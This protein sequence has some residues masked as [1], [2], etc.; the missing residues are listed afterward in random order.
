MW[1][2]KTI[3]LTAILLFLS[4]A[5]YVLLGYC[6][7]QDNFYVN[8][9]LYTVVF[10]AFIGLYSLRASLSTTTLWR[11]TLFM[12]GIL[13]CSIPA[14]SPDVYRF[15]WDGELIVK[16]IHPYAFTPNELMNSGTLE[17]TPYM[18]QLYASITDLSRANYS[19]YPTLNQLYFVIPAGLTESVFSGVVVMRLLMLLTLLVG[20]HFIQKT[21]EVLLIPK[22]RV[23]LFALNPLLIIEATG[24]L[25]FEGVMFSLFAIALYFMVR[26][27]W[28]VSALFVALAINVKLT[29][30]L[31]LPF[32]L[33]YLGWRKSMVFYLISLS[34]S[35]TLL[36]VF[37]WPSTTA[38]FLQS[39]ELYFNNFE[40]NSSLYRFSTYLFR[41]I[42][43]YDTALI[44][45]PLL[46]KIALMIILFLALYSLRRGKESLFAFL[47][48]GYVVYLLFATT[49]HPWYLIVPLGLSVFTRFKFMIYWSFIV[50]VS[51]GFYASGESKWVDILVAIEYIG[52]LIIV[53]LEYKKRGLLKDPFARLPK[54]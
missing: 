15:L 39:V 46:S 22:E 54:P 43:T 44:I 8:F 35:A 41:P 32:F 50:V 52:L 47:L 13:L 51:Y 14:L 6:T 34:S 42:L 10:G 7:T 53:L 37:L 25:H 20:V 18:S 24:N 36:M 31:L 28:W 48:M 23:F 1:Q 11:L 33:N 26:K 49:V 5:G 3:I 45:G 29:P 40:F 9:T 16:G 4:A 2:N 19:V 12:H 17:M 38:N 30:L 27:K 21:L